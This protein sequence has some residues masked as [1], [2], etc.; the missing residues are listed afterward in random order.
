VNLEERIFQARRAGCRTALMSQGVSAD[1][2]DR[3]CDAWEAEAT[4]RGIGGSGTFWDDGRQWIDT[5][6]IVRK[7]SPDVAAR[8]R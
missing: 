7:T 2:A 6:R 8:A 3:W 1:E 5:Q 4:R